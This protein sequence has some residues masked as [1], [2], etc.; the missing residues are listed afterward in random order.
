MLEA[1][2]ELEAAARRLLR[3][4]APFPDLTAHELNARKAGASQRQITRAMH[5]GATDRT[6]HQT[7]KDW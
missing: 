5:Q 6:H 2:A 4:G 1:L 7:R 3:E